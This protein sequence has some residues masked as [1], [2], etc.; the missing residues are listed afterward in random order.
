MADVQ[1]VINA[2]ERR[3]EL[4][5]RSLG[6]APPH[7]ADVMAYHQKLRNAGA[8]CIVGATRELIPALLQ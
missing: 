3:P 4:R 1:T 8:D 5:W 2:R 7:V 6:V